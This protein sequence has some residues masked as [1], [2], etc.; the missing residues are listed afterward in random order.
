MPRGTREESKESRVEENVVAGVGREQRSKTIVHRQEALAV[1]LLDRSLPSS[2][3]EPGIDVQLDVFEKVGKWVAIKN[4]LTDLEE[5]DIDRFKAR[6]HGQAKAAESRARRARVDE[7]SR[8]DA[9]KAR[10]PNG[11]DSGD[12]GDSLDPGE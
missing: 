2:G 7:T 12:D 11:G 10:L 5:S 1:R 6:I 4:R 8:L 9:I 3:E